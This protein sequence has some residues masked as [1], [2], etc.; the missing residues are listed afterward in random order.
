MKALFSGHVLVAEDNPVNEEVACEYLARYGCTFEVARDGAQAIKCFEQGQFDFILMDCHMPE[1]DGFAAARRIRTIEVKN[2][3]AQTPIIAL[4]A[5][6]FEADRQACAAAGMNDYLGKPFTNDE[7]QALLR[8]WA[9]SVVATDANEGEAP[10][11]DR[12]ML[13]KL[14]HDMP[15]LHTRM[16]S[17]YLA[18]APK[19][20]D[21]ILAAAQSGEA[22]VLML[23]AHSLKSS[24]A[25]VGA[26]HV[27][28]LSR[29]LE[30][31]ANANDLTD[32]VALA[33]DLQD[34][35]RIAD[36]ELRDELAQKA[37]PITRTVRS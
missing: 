29:K 18:H 13:S 31:L 11:I 24:S 15:Q 35:N 5:N 27:L 3:R 26:T 7:F 33:K 17:A 12:V 9:K 22:A 30:A 1:M 6:A 20:V 10:E 21:E 37:S 23:A 34:R 2:G 28:E 8:R 32:A 4:T 36:K 19:L 25:N 14:A 16:L